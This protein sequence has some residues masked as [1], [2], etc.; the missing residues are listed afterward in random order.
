[1]KA[2]KKKKKIKELYFQR[3]DGISSRCRLCHDI[4]KHYGNTTNLINHIMRKH[5][6]KITQDS[7]QKKIS[8]LENQS[9][10]DDP[11]IPSTSSKGVCVL[12]VCYQIN[13]I[14]FFFSNKIG[15]FSYCFYYNF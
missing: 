5:T 11:A 10:T 12:S 7:Q 1:M 3:I 15:I 9:D 14:V 2:S 4:Y 8:Y 6:D 13:Q